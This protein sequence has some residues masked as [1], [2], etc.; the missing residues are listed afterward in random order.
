MGNMCVAIVS[1]V[2][3]QVYYQ[4]VFQHDPKKRQV[5]DLNEKSF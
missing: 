1:Q 3:K 5:K 4:A 2:V